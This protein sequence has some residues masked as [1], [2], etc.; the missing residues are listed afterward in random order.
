MFTNSTSSGEAVVDLIQ[1]LRLVATDNQ[2]GIYNLYNSS[3]DTNSGLIKASDT[4]IRRNIE[5]SF[6]SLVTGDEDL[7]KAEHIY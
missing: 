7:D 4:N 1:G 2:S 5:A 6:Y 3:S